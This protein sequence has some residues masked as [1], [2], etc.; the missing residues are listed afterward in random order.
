[1][2]PGGVV[3][4]AVATKLAGPRHRCALPR[5]WPSGLECGRVVVAGLRGERRTRQR[6]KPEP[7]ARVRPLARRAPEPQLRSSLTFARSTDATRSS[8]RFALARCSSAS[9]SAGS[10]S[11]SCSPASRLDVGS[12][13]RWL[14]LALTFAAA[15]CN[16]VAMFVP[17]RE[18][19]H[20]SRA[21]GSCSTSGRGGLIGFVALLVFAGGAN[22]TLLLFLTVP[23][24]A[25]VQSGWRRAF[26]LAVS[27]ATCT[28][29]V[30]L[31]PL[32]VGATAMRLA[33]VAAAVAVALVLA[34][35]IRR[36]AA[37]HTEAAAR[38]ELERTLATE[39]NHRIKNNLQTVA[40][41]LLLGRPDG[42]DGQA[43][44]DTASPH[45]LDRDACTRLLTERRRPRRRRRAAR[46]ASPRAR[47]FRS[48][49]RPTRRR[50]TRRPRRSS[51]IVAN[52]LITNAFRH[53]APPI[54]VRLDARRADAAAR[55]RRRRRPGRRRDRPRTRSSSAGWSSRA[56]DGRFELGAARRRRHPRR[57][58]LPGGAR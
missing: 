27:A 10:R 13:H 49:S 45:P 8:S 2:A 28:L 15:G 52:E 11:S 12:R 43:F 31:V 36:E 42:G 48:R 6:W 30:A 51:D 57:G 47:R 16:T 17:W 3:M 54:A 19:L 53:G 4:N 40:D 23:F 56:F 39:A 7:Q 25:V 24:I 41:L 33:L 1:M 21:A 46:A 5:P 38:A 26:W 58:R 29:A 55:R 35:A 20:G 37:A 14:L 32:P 50:S 34:R 22:F 18:W 9:G 44:D